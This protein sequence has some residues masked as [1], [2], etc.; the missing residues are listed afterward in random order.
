MLTLARAHIILSL[1]SVI[2]YWRSW[3]LTAILSGRSS[4]RV[5]MRSKHGPWALI[6]LPMY[7]YPVIFWAQPTLT[8]VLA[9]IHLP[10]LHLLHHLV[11]RMISLLPSMTLQEILCGLRALAVALTTRRLGALLTALAMCSSP[12]VLA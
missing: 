4:L 5:T 6:A 2:S 10:P 1:T 9:F 12:A 3:T 11:L 7:S 8:P